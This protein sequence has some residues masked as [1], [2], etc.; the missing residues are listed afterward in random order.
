MRESVGGME[1]W[2]RQEKEGGWEGAV[3]L[4][5]E[6]GLGKRRG[7]LGHGESW[8]RDGLKSGKWGKGEERRK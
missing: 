3:R 2:M 4:E 6:W 5:M 8:K 1:L 7:R